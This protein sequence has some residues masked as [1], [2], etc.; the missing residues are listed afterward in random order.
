M[1]HPEN[2]FI[3][4]V[5]RKLRPLKAKGGYY[6]AKL[7]VSGNNGFPDCWY[8]GRGGDLWAEYKWISDRDFPVRS[9]TMIPI[10]LSPNQR[11][12]LNGRHDEGRSVCCIVGSPQGHLILH[13][14]FP[15][16]ISA[17]DFISSAVDTDSVVDYILGKTHLQ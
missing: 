15:E 3:Q 6:F 1:A 17:A 11:N 16:K 7:Q 10:G 12:W 5:H 9:T 13:F 8:S 2:R 4:T 14:P